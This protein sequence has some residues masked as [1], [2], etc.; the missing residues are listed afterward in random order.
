M[1]KLRTKQESTALSA[2]L[3][4]LLQGFLLQEDKTAW[5]TLQLQQTIVREFFATLGLH[6]HLDDND[7]YA[8]L[9]TIPMG[10]CH[11]GKVTSESAISFD[12]SG[13]VHIKPWIYSIKYQRLNKLAISMNL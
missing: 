10:E 12:M 4:K 11:D 8:F 9:R 1:S 2:V 13:C 7:G 3:I 6:L 5:E